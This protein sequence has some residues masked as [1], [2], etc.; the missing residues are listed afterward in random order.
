MALSTLPLGAEWAQAQPRM[1]THVA[2]VGDSITAGFAASSPDKSYPSD[3]QDLFGD[4]VKVMN[5]GHSGTTMLSDGYGD[6]PY[7]DQPEYQ[8]ATSFVTGAGA[9]A[10]VDVIIML[11][12]N[13]SK[14]F[15]WTPTGKPKNDQQYVT[16]Y[17]A[18]I[19]HFL[20]LSPKPVV[21]LALPLTAYANSYSISGTVIHDE[22]LPLIEQLAA[23]QKQPT[24]DLNTPTANHPEYFTD[25]VHPN[26]AGYAVV[27]QIMHDGLL[28][29]PTVSVTTPVAGAALDAANPIQLTADASGGTVPISSVEFFQATTSIGKATVAP[30]RVSWNAPPGGYVLTAKAIDTTQASA[31][32][33]PVSISVAVQNSGGGGGAGGAAGGSAGGAANPAG[34]SGTS[35]AAGASAV[36]GSAGVAASAGMGAGGAAQVPSGTTDSGGCGCSLA[37]NPRERPVGSAFA[38]LLGLALVGLQRRASRRAKSRHDHAE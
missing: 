23:E 26:D 1:P 10:L 18:M 8:A 2:C 32:S 7:E 36:S 27:A 6:L 13:D 33:A 28:R 3:L 24:I 19:Q 21:Y 31:T 15:N 20:A 14:D 29:V 38:A 4:Q 22:E 37:K 17:R 5:F 16:D 35:N 11:G 30:F 9:N 12:T 25:G 34:A